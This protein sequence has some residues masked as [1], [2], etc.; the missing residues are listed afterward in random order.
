MSLSGRYRSLYD[1]DYPTPHRRMPINEVHRHG[2]PRSTRCGA[3][4]GI[5]NLESAPPGAG[6]RIEDQE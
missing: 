4:T 3:P 1:A 5:C 2:T 6:E